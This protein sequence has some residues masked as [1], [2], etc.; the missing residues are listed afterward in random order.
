MKFIHLSDLHIGKI[1]NKFSMLTDQQYI[2]EQI[3][4]IIKSESPDAVII[5]G[6]VYDRSFPPSDA[7]TELDEFIFKLSEENFDTFIISGNHDSAER[8][9]FGSR[10][11]SKNGIHIS[12]VYNGRVEPV[13]LTDEFGE[14][15]V[16]MLPFI[17]PT[18]VKNFFPEKADD[19]KSSYTIA[20]KV[21]IENMNVDTSKRNIIVSHQFVNG[22]KTSESEISVGGSDNVDC[23]VY[24]PFDY[25]ALGHIHSPQSISGLE[26]LRYCGTPLK[27]SFSEYKD[28]SVTVVEM[29]EKGTP[30]T[31]RE[32]PLKPMHD[33]RIIEGS[34]DEVH[35]NGSSDP[36]NEDYV[37]VDLTDKADVPN[38]MQRLRDVY[39]TIMGMRYLREKRTSQSDFSR[40]ANV[41]EKTPLELFGD[42]FKNITGEELDDKKLEYMK[43]LIE[44]IEDR[45]DE[46][47]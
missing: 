43:A 2:L 21:A 37:R 9:S 28:K 25:T 31:V 38:A 7:V 33:M 40:T 8:L 34:F 29:S 44:R 42:F 16:Y 46:T 12:P 13:T 11:M 30:V 41:K 5:A 10:I 35:S 27:Y 14:V 19:I 45:E 26:H 18:N 17:K 32:I 22:V 6:D 23:D 15:N 20:L 47:D 3:L 36:N 4:G 39:P 24:E 1:V